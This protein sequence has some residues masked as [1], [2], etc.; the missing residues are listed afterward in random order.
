MLKSCTLDDIS[1]LIACPIITLHPERKEIIIYG[2]AVHFSKD[3]YKDENG[4][5]KYG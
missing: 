2:G 1:I 3:S 5:I 4:I